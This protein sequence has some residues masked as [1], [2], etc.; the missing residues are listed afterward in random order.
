MV[1][2]FHLLGLLASAKLSKKCAS[3][4]II[5]ILQRGAKVEYMGGG[6]GPGKVVKG[7]NWLQNSHCQS[8]RK[9]TEFVVLLPKEA[10]DL[11]ACHSKAN[12]QARLVERKVC[13][14]SHAGNLG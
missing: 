14:I 10:V 6:I 2:F 13:F 11:A 1:N 3:D 4:T 5:W 9:S 8:I 12:K 7:P